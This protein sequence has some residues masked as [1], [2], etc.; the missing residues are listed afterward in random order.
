LEINYWHIDS[1]TKDMFKGNPA[2]VC[3][4][5]NPLPEDLM[6]NIAKEMK[7]SE[8]AFVVPTQEQSR[9][10]LRWFTPKT[11]V[12]LCGHA[13]L[14]S[15]AVLYH[16]Y[17]EAGNQI[18]FETLSGELHTQLKGHRIEMDFPSCPP[19]PLAL[20]QNILT[21]LNL[22][23]FSEIGYAEAL[24][25]ILVVLREEA[26][27]ISFRPDFETWKRILF[28]VEMKGVILTAK[29]D[30]SYDFVSR[31]FAPWLGIDED[32]VTGSSHTVLAPY[33]KQK[34][35]KNTFNAYQCSERGGA[36][37]LTVAENRVLVEG[38][39]AIVLKGTLYTS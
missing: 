8:T 23:S 21:M 3:F 39:Y 5:E 28:P 33:W 19:V 32:P 11:E 1:F 27:V 30:G 29:S 38:D 31:F 7:V 25:K 24:G 14:A 15:A 4:S 12:R 16:Y 22:P 37:F 20:S 26:A 36:L 18:Q 6:Q 35:G 9:Y 34:L 17:G 13:T 10:H 2:G